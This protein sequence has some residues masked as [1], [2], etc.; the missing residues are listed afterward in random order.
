M[1]ILTFQTVLP[2]P[3]HLSFFSQERG[4]ARNTELQLNEQLH[5]VF[6]RA[7]NLLYDG[8][9]TFVEDCENQLIQVLHM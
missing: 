8:T 6:D 7:G 5:Y 9:R 4:Q 3:G 1:S 2:P